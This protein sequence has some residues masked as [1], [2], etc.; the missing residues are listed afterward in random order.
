MAEGKKNLPSETETMRFEDGFEALDALLGCISQSEEWAYIQRHD[1]LILKAEETLYQ[2]LEK[3]KEI[4]GAD[5]YMSLEDAICVYNGT[6]NDAAVFYGLRIAAKL[7]Y[8]FGKPLEMSRYFLE[9]DTERG[10][11]V[12]YNR[13]V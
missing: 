1:A 13:T 2:R 8:A 10:V 12:G 5:Y 6:F 7:F 11:G 9:R 4:A 3:I